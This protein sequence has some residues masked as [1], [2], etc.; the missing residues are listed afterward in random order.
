MATI[1]TR[2]GKGARLSWTEADANFTNLNT[3]KLEAAAITNMLEAADIG[4]SVQAY[5]ANTTKND[6]AN[7]FTAIQKWAKGADVASANALT[8]GTDGN[9][10]DITGTTAI[11]SIGTLGIGTVV[12]LH[13]DDALT[14]THHSTDLVLPGA[15]NITTAAGDEAELVEYATGDWRCTSYTKASGTAVVSAKMQDFRLTLTTGVPVTTADVTGATTIYCCPYK[16]NQISLYDGA[17]WVTRTSA[18]FS[19]ALGTLTSGKPYDVFCYDNAGTPTLEFLVWTNDTTRATALAYQDG[20]L[21]KAGAPTRRYLGTFYTTAATT[22]EDSV[23][24]RYLWNYYHRSLRAMY[25]QEATSSWS[26]STATWRQANGA[27]ANQLNFIQG[28]AED[29]VRVQVSASVSNSTATGRYPSI[30]VGIDSTSSPSKPGPLFTSDAYARPLFCDYSGVIPS[31]GRHY[32]AWLEIG[33]GADT[34][35]WFGDNGDATKQQS[36]ISGEVMA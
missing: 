5:D 20:V 19:L 36:G 28:V 21:C 10:F 14:L 26:Y 30:G 1:V 33:A 27:S 31:A 34:Q 3:D 35:S 15:A 7:T 16:G 6:V 9:Y 2:A 29:A 32:F 23:A 12:K 18:Q 11:T 8:L 24:N 4:V 13:F 25:V 22:T 17:A